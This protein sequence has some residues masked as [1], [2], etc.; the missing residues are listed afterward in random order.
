MILAEELMRAIDNYISPY[1]LEL[2][3]AEPFFESRKDFVGKIET[4]L[5]L[6]KEKVLCINIMYRYKIALC[7]WKR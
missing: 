7:R 5:L 4:E 3:P 1:N 2:I 6:G